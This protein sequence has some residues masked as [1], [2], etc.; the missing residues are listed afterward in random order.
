[1]KS[2]HPFGGDRARNEIMKPRQSAL[3]IIENLYQSGLRFIGRQKPLEPASFDF[4]KLKRDATTA[5]GYPRF[6]MVNV[7]YDTHLKDERDRS[8][9]TVQHSS[10]GPSGGSSL[11]HNDHCYNRLVGN[12]NRDCQCIK[13]NSEANCNQS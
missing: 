3:T 12:K 4:F 10:V 2:F 11:C 8:I 7:S 1:M 5:F 9:I 13:D 6:N